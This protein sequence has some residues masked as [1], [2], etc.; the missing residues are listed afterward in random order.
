MRKPFI[1]GNWKMNK[2]S[3]E[4]KKFV[5]TVA[6]ELSNISNIDVA[7]CPNFIS[8]SPLVE[9]A[10]STVLKIGSQ[11]I[12]FAQSGAYTGEISGEML[13][14]VGVD[15]AIIGHSE[16]RQYF[17]ETNETVNLRLKAA[18]ENNLVGIMCVGETLEEREGSKRDIILKEQL[19]KGLKDISVDSLAKV[20]IAYEPVWAIGTGV[21]ASPEEAQEAHKFIRQQLTTLFGEEKAEQVVI[22]YGGSVKPSNVV[23]LLACPDID[24]A[25]VGG[26]SLK[27][28]DFI[29]LIKNASA[30]L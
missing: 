25:L 30:S 7:I 16:R 15:Y 28:E 8:L 21:T 18:L 5:K 27:E 2:T 9:K 22:Q 3:E 24:G 11:N 26:A 4:G 12:H 17:G 13:Q 10:K 20:V 1:A 29:A 14:E 19:F 23:E 6:S